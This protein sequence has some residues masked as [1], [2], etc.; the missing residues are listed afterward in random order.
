MSGITARI[1]QHVLHVNKSSQNDLNDLNLFNSY[2]NINK[3]YSPALNLN[4]KLI[5]YIFYTGNG[6]EIS[7]KIISPIE[8]KSTKI[9]GIRRCILCFRHT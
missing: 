2:V 4:T 7:T 5:I 6:K 1:Y 8:L 3:F 9:I